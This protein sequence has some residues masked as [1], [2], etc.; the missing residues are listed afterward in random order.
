MKTERPALYC[1]P[2]ALAISAALTGCSDPEERRASVHFHAEAVRNTLE[3]NRRI[4]TRFKSGQLKEP[5]YDM[6]TA[7]DVMARALY[8]LP[9]RIEK[10]ATT[11]IAERKAAAVKAHKL[12]AEL[13]PKLEGLKFELAPINAKLD[14]IEKL[15]DEVERE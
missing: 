1:V 7:T 6:K 14:E 11:R 10:K 12:F 9:E 3:I 8:G 2:L 13:R 5:G 4:V 15:I